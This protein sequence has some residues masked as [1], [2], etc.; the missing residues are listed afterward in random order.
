MREQSHKDAM[1]SA[2]RA[3]FARL[4]ARGIEATLAPRDPPAAPEPA[5][6]AEPAVT[7]A[8]PIVPA[9]PPEA[10][11]GRSWFARLRGR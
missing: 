8:A 3:D 1:A 2:L 5:P 4:R 11:A 6:P 10:T 7:S 9:M